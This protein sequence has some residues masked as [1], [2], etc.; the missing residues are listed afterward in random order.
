MQVSDDV[1]TFGKAC[2]HLLASVAIHQPLTEE[3]VL[4]VRHYC[5]ELLVKIATHPPEQDGHL[6]RS[7]NH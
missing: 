4:F 5:K 6:T 1:H 7:P 3:E 2:E